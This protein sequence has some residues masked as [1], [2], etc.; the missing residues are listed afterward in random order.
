MFI[1]F[2][3]WYKKKIEKNICIKVIVNH[4]GCLNIIFSHNYDIDYINLLT[5][6]LLE[7]YSNTNKNLTL[8]SESYVQL[9]Y[10]YIVGHSYNK[11]CHDHSIVMKI[12]MN[13]SLSYH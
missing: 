5:Y 7:H 13:N 12:E 1:F 6:I 8:E 10:T 2:F 11:Q 4:V 9:I 3:F